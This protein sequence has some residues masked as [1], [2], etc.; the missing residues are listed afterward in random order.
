MGTINSNLS[1][2]KVGDQVATIKY[3]WSPV[4][5][6]SMDDKLVR[7]GK[8][9]YSFSGKEDKND[10]VASAW[11]L[12]PSDLMIGPKP[13]VLKKGDRVLCGSLKTKRYFSHMDK[14]MFVTFSGG[15][16]EWTSDGKTMRCSVCVKWEPA[17]KGIPQP[18][19][20]EK[21]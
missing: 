4:T 14:A 10:R 12:P 7:V 13:A 2:V 20:G 1:N 3:G 5:D 17:V 6:V 8:T 19:K 21:A 15:M 9:W 18:P 16:D 11:V